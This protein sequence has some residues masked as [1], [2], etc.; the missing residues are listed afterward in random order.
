MFPNTIFTTGAYLVPKQITDELGT[1]WVWVVDAFEDDTYGDGEYLNGIECVS[2]T[3][4][5]LIIEETKD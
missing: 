5:G 1:R 4:E 3:L 2:E